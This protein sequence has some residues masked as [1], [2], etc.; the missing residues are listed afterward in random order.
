[1]RKTGLVS[2]ETSAV[3]DFVKIAPAY[4]SHWACKK[5]VGK[6]GKLQ[7]KDEYAGCHTDTECASNSVILYVG[8]VS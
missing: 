8:F 1:M 6:V 4:E 7:T 3:G 2:T 5:F